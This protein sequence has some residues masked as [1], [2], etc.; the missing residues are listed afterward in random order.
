MTR[1]TYMCVCVCVRERERERVICMCIWMY[2]EQQPS[3]A[4]P[5]IDSPDEDLESFY[6]KINTIIPKRLSFVIHEDEA[7]TKEQIME[8]RDLFFFSTTFH[9]EY[10][11]LC[12]D[13]G[14]SNLACIHLLCQ[15]LQAKMSDPRLQARELVYYAEG[16]RA[17]R[18]NAAFLLGCYC[19]L[20]EGWT[21]EEA[22]ACLERIGGSKVFPPYQD[23]TYCEST[24]DLT[25]LDCYRGLLRGRDEGWYDTTTFNLERYEMFA[26]PSHYDM[27]MI[28]PKF[29]AFRGPN[30]INE[31]FPKP[32]EFLE[33]FLKIGVTGMHRH[34]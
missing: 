33:E 30:A 11:P 26:D 34:T 31:R 6:G 5:R 13:F 10:Q 8:R 28:C 9:E 21:P 27:H 3:D 19:V 16:D 12:A 29:V 20:M 25:V 18:T 14:P 4:P 32:E 15:E 7:Q 17:R 22:A 23:A 2:S 1:Y 24:F